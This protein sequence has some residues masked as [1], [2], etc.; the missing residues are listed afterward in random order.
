MRHECRANV[1]DMSATPVEPNRGVR[2]A[3]RIRLRVDA[4]EAR[5]EELGATNDT[6]RAELCDM[7]RNNLFR[8]RNG[9]APSLELAMHMAEKVGLKVED[10]FE[11]ES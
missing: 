4:F 1:C 2:V 3:S 10:L 7:S 6:S 8:M 11:V 9:Q 5:C